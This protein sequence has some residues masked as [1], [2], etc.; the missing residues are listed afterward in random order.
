[1]HDRIIR[2][3]NNR[4]W[5]GCTKHKAPEFGCKDCIALTRPKAPEPA[6][7][8]PKEPIQM[9]GRKKKFRG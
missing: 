9:F 2:A 1:M 4:D 7:A 5:W 8:P 3:W 6:A